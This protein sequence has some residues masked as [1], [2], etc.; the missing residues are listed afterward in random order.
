MLLFLVSFTFENFLNGDYLLNQTQF[1]EGYFLAAEQGGVF[2]FFPDKDS[3]ISLNRNAGLLSNN[4]KFVADV[5]SELFVLTN[6]GITVFD[7]NL[8]FLRNIT[9]NP[10]IQQDTILNSIFYY[11]DTIV[12]TSNSGLL[13][14]DKRTDPM[15]AKSYAFGSPVYAGIFFNKRFYFAASNGIYYSNVI[16][17]PYI[18]I[19]GISD[20]TFSFETRG[21]TLF[22]CGIWGTGYI[23]GSNI[24]IRNNGIQ[25][26]I[27]YRLRNIQDTLYDCTNDGLFKFNN[28]VWKK[29]G[30]D[31]K[32][33][34]IRDVFTYQNVL[35][36]LTYGRGIGYLKDNIWDYIHPPGPGNNEISDFAEDSS[37][38]IWMAHGLS[39]RYWML[40]SDSAGV[41]K[42][43]NRDN[44]WSIQGRLW[45]IE[46]GKGEELWLGC[47]Q[48]NGGLYRWK[49]R[50]TIPEKIELNTPR[51]CV[52]EMEMSPDGNNLYISF[53]DNTVVRL[54]IRDD[55]LIPHYYTSKEYFRWVRTITFNKDD[56]AYCGF[57]PSLDEIGITILHPDGTMEKVN[58]LPPF[59][60]LSLTRDIRDRIWAGLEGCAVVISGDSVVDVYDKT[61][62]LLDDRVDGIES[63]FQGGIWFLHRGIGISYLRPDGKWRYFRTTDGLV[64]TSV[65]EGTD[66]LFFSNEHKLYI[67]TDNGLSILTPDFHIPSVPHQVN[68]Y[69]NPFNLNRDIFINFASDS[70]IN[71]EIFIFTPSGKVLYKGKISGNVFQWKVDGKIQSGLLLYRILDGKH[72]F[73]SGSFVV[74]K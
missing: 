14:W 64:S 2:G 43:Y 52:A 60:T 19:S 51:D 3:F 33:S 20:A 13:V 49:N 48:D 70:L 40:T 24:Y 44:E 46:A 39:N 11:S 17:G 47:W 21:D 28:S 32:N 38:T 57:S 61:K 74:I 18:H 1:G 26:L 69:P 45:Q 53:L 56:D 6:D 68:V 34:S 42:V 37:G 62:G 59:S 58:G 31:Y 67:G 7:K 25:G 15:N 55:T 8:N 5:D 27:S 36:T 71:K 63:D 30:Q 54:E 23:M 10:S 16:T 4:V 35:Y 50:D 66:P 65:Q 12:I 41:W 9:F 29:I 73:A 72:I 22:S